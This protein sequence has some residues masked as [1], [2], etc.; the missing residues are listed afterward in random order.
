L[1][2][3]P[4]RAILW[5]FA[6][7]EFPTLR[8]GLKLPFLL[9][10]PVGTRGGLREVR[11]PH[12]T[13]AATTIW[14]EAS[15]LALDSGFSP[16]QRRG[17]ALE[18]PGAKRAGTLN[19]ALGGFRENGGDLLF[20]TVGIPVRQDGAVEVVAIHAKPAAFTEPDDSSWYGV[21]PVPVE[22]RHFLGRMTVTQTEGRS[23]LTVSPAVGV[24]LS[25]ARHPGWWGRMGFAYQL[26]S[27]RTGRLQEVELVAV[28][29]GTTAH[30]VGFFGAQVRD[31]VAG[32][33]RFTLE[34]NGTGFR[35]DIRQ[36][37]L[38]KPEMTLPGVPLTLYGLIRGET[39]IGG[40]LFVE[41]EAARFHAGAVWV[42]TP[43]EDERR[44]EIDAEASARFS[45]PR[46]RG[47]LA[48]RTAY[49]RT[50][51]ERS[52]WSIRPAVA[53]QSPGSL[54]IECS[55]AVE[56]RHSV[57]GWLRNYEAAARMTV[58]R[59]ATRYS[60]RFTIGYDGRD[61]GSCEWGLELGWSTRST[62][63]E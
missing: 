62:D 47:E 17:A 23:Q 63:P 29:A 28:F 44:M 49:E 7:G 50:T 41:S 36:G 26:D 34:R 54:R 20:A 18:I 12:P 5:T 27:V 6:D 37:A 4:A 56:A 43:K 35:L 21:T 8:G 13:S 11:T 45:S 40:S 1:S 33:F 2:G 14:Q 61:S 39:E 52:L 32:A 3:E 57:E 58:D 19:A 51:P 48:F 30:Y 16:G 59:D 55:G 60:L 53:W 25:S 38:W 31:A 9:V 46:G 42:A 15:E 10:G 22:S 24:S